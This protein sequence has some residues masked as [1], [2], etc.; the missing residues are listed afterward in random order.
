M[1]DAHLSCAFGAIG[2]SL[3]EPSLGFPDSSVGKQS[4]CSAGDPGL[5]PG[6]GRSTGEGIGYPFQYS[7]TFLVAQL[8]RNPPAMWETWLRSLGW[9]DP[10]EKGK[11]TYS[12]ILA[13]RIPWTVYPWGRKETVPSKKIFYLFMAA[14]GLCCYAQAFS[15]CSEQGLLSS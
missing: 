7:W 2:T 14:L 8:V 4:A 12:N 11:A 13:W 6:L 9:E 5:I 3:P 1:S 15:G 10:L